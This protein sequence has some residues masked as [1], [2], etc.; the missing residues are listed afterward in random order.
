MVSGFAI[1]LHFGWKLTLVLCFGAPFIAGAT[2]QQNMI[3]KK[4]QIRD[5][6][7]METAGRVSKIFEK[8][9]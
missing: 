2:Y 6:K 3:L 8:L 5:T 1:A 4:N 9:E 7:L